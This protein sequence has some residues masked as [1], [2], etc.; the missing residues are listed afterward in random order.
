MVGKIQGRSGRY[1]RIRHN[2]TA[3][4]HGV[5]FQTR[6]LSALASIAGETRLSMPTVTPAV[7]ALT[8]AGIARETTGRRRGRIYSYHEYMD[9]M[10]EGTSLP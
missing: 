5:S 3:W 9:I 7:Q 10:N 6:P 4:P 2:E 1:R 8:S